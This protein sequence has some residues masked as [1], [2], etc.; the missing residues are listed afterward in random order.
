MFL[1]YAISIV[2]YLSNLLICLTDSQDLKKF[3]RPMTRLRS[4]ANKVKVGFLPLLSGNIP[5]SPLLF[6]F[7]F[8]FP[9]FPMFS[10]SF[11]FLVNFAYAYFLLVISCSLSLTTN[12]YSHSLRFLLFFTRKSFFLL[13]QTHVYTDIHSYTYS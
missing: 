2:S 1:I 4:E 5:H 7:H 13:N 10:C 3:P 8:H 11:P 6:L 9:F 12:A